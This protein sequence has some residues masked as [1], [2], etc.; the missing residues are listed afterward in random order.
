MVGLKLVL[1]TTPRNWGDT[2]VATATVLELVPRY[3][4]CKTA[5]LPAAQLNEE[6]TAMLV[7]PLVGVGLEAAPTVMILSST[8]VVIDC[9]GKVCTLGKAPNDRNVLV[10]A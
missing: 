4:A 8:T 10:P 5:L 2:G 7:A 3:T 1:V 6:V 9:G